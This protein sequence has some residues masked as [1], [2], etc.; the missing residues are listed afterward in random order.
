M[1]I[2][3][4]E[5]YVKWKLLKNSQLIC[6]INL[7]AFPGDNAGLFITHSILSFIIKVTLNFLT[8]ILSITNPLKHEFTHWEVP[9]PRGV[10]QGE[11]TGAERS[12]CRKHWGNIFGPVTSS[13]NTSNCTTFMYFHLLVLTYCTL[14]S[15]AA[16]LS[17]TL[18]GVFAE[19]W[20][21]KSGGYK[22]AFSGT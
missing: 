15:S 8:A 7:M 9:G 18:Q 16:S 13:I 5:M 2:I 20:L 21:L 12:C 14:S 6:D 17:S 10:E 11:Q 1:K 22:F 3:S 19:F 4:C